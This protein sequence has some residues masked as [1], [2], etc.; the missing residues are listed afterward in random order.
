MRAIAQV[1]R[2]YLKLKLQGPVSC[3]KFDFQLLYSQTTALRTPHFY[4]QLR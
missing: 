3:H 4:G 1:I 2:I